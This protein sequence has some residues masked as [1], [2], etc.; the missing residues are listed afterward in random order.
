MASADIR[1]EKLNPFPG[2]RPFAPDESDYF[3]GRETES[4]E[5]AGKL[6][7]NRF[8]AVTGASGSGKSSLILCGLLPEVK[9]LSSKEAVK[10]KFVSM[11][12]GNDP[13]PNL[14]GSFVNVISNGNNKEI[15]LEEILK[16]LKKN[17]DA[18]T[19]I[20]KKYSSDINGRFLLFVDQFEELF[21][22]GSQ[23]AGTDAGI[24]INDF[25]NLLINAVNPDNPDFYLV[26]AIRS[27]LLSSCEQYRGFTELINNSNFLVSRMNREHFREAIIGPVKN[28]GAEID[29]DLVEMLIGEI[30]DHN[31]QLP[32]LQHA[33]MRTW[34]HWKEQNEPERAL[35]Y[36]DYS[37]IGTMKDAISRHADEI[38]EGLSQNS[39][40]V[41]EKFFKAITGR[42]SD[43]KGIRYPS[44]IKTIRS[45]VRC[46]DEDLLEVIEEFRNPS[47]SIV[48]PHYPVQLDEDSVIDLSHESLIH[49]WERLKRWVDEEY[50]SVQMYLRL[51]VTSALYQQGKTGLLKQPDLQ[52]AVNW[53]EENK[54]TLGWA[55]KYDPAFERAMVFLRTSEKEYLESE[56][57][58]ARQ[59]R[60]RLHRI[61][62][63]SSFLGA[64]AILTA[65][66]MIAAFISKLSADNRRKIAERQKEE[67]SVQKN[68]AEQYAA[69]ALKRSVE[70]DSNA[71]AAIRREQMERLMRRNAENRL[72]SGM[73]DIDE[74]RRQ[75]EL[76]L[77]KSMLAM[78]NTDSVIR[79]KNETERLRMISVAKSMSLRS[80]QMTGENELQA[81]LAYQAYLFNKKNQGSR[82]DAD[83]YM[84]LYNL[85]SLKGSNNLKSYSGFGGTVRSIA[86]IPGRKEFFTSDS[87]GKVLRWDLENKEQSFRVI[88]SDN[89]VTDVLAISPKTDWLACGGVNSSIRM[90]PVSG[91]DPGY[92]LKGHSGAIK[93]LIFSYDGNYL[94]SAA[95]DGRVLKWDLTARTSTDVATG[96]MQITSID[97]SPGNRFLA[98][99]SDQGNAAVWNQENGSD[100][101]TIESPGKKIRSIRFK[102]DEER[103]AVGYDDGM[104]ELWDIA[105]KKKI[106]EFRAHSGEVND[107]RFNRRFEQMATAGNDGTL[108]L[109]DTGDL[110]NP[111]VSF[112]DNEGLVIAFE[113]SPD[114]EMI[115]AGNLG[116]E[117]KIKVR[118]AYAD[119]FAADGC[120]YVTRNFTPDEW[121]AY[122]GKDITYEKTCP[123]TD[124]K[125]RVR[126]V[127]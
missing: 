17:P 51:S 69:V 92:E 8:V 112:N 67:I 89:E 4:T 66:T 29:K 109:W 22:Y 98:G 102:P 85:A 93:S 62:I 80:L 64:I 30:A 121:L 125:I 35:D 119:S 75:S 101:F 78:L 45:A 83:I 73:R 38:Y 46:T 33:L 19:E 105:L 56:E 61:K 60:W 23:E 9:R 15:Y 54:P 68:A 3:F 77:H 43:N 110:I 5:I 96:G 95:L 28:A 117:P 18:I 113:F 6:I 116:S 49:L 124:L 126:E 87:E 10:W 40:Q 81:L 26:I 118:P 82:N 32:V 31:Y 90:I 127:R 2:L 91:N 14:A 58:K 25:I 107:I 53:R 39:K 1:D 104:I 114:G 11:R 12:P 70:S 48:S 100:K 108:K 59:Q 86:F 84:G 20:I 36:T 50:N 65:L 24:R 16:L 88:Y 94:Y 42:G 111:P 47:I 122:V 37:S 63:I 99:I 7:R 115:L 57:R 97:L 71:I 72:I 55:K 120:S 21:R 52:L 44:D 74:A 27:D 34:M 76:A 103:I 79:V 106:A 41:C 123:G 13:L